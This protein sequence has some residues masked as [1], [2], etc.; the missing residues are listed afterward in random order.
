MTST[1]GVTTTRPAQ[2]GVAGPGCVNGWIVPTR[3]TAV[4]VEPLDAIRRDMGIHGRV[5]GDRDAL[6][7]RSGVPW[8][9]QPRP[10][11]VEWWYVNAQLVDD[12]RSEPGVWWHGGHPW[13]REQ[14]PP[15][16][17]AG[18]QSPDWRGFIGESEPRTVEGLPGTW[19]GLDF[20]FLTGEDGEKPG[21]PNEV[22]HCL[23]GT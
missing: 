11:F 1:D 15:F 6:L 7:H 8:I 9:L 23:D 17:T 4:R 20:D 14:R 10:P 12:P 19:V 5:R 16:D 2:A 3:G 22:V 13:S 18:Y 21:L